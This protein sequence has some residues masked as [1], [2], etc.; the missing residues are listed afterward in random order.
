MADGP[1]WGSCP[2]TAQAGE[3]SAYAVCGAFLSQP[4][5]LVSDCANVVG[6][7]VLPERAR[8]AP[9]RPCA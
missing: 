9:D 2:Q 1:A 8:L 5:Q 3:F 4:S 6:M 7:H